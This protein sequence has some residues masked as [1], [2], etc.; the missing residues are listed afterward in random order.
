MDIIKY[1]E[2]PEQGFSLK[3]DLGGIVFTLLSSWV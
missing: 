3:L 1:F 2:K